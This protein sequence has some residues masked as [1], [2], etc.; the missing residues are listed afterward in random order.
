MT[1]ND[2]NNKNDQ[3][4]SKLGRTSRGGAGRC[5]ALISSLRLCLA[6]STF[7]A[8]VTVV[9][10]RSID[11]ALR[12]STVLL[13]AATSS[14]AAASF[15]DTRS[16]SSSAACAGNGGNGRAERVSEKRPI[17]RL[18]ADGKIQKNTNQSTTKVV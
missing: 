18:L 12:S 8:V 4:S 13:S 1:I 15:W 14:S 7:L 6:S 17:R 3:K 10:T 16:F 9:A 5:G 11:T 2:Q